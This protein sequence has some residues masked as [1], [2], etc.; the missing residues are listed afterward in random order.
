MSLSI[1]S[2]LLITIVFCLTI[3][4]Q[5]KK[6]GPIITDFGQVWE[7]TNPEFKVDPSKEY[8]AVFDIMNSPTDT[9]KI[10]SSIET[11]ARFLNMHA[12]SGVPLS[13]LKFVL[14]VHNKASKDIISNEAY[15]KRFGVQNPNYDLINALMNAGGQVIFCGQSSISRG[16]PK[17]ELIDGVQMSLSAMTALIHFQ[18]KDYRLIKF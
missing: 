7:I 8:K 11:A 4:A 14:V 1:K 10:N 13:N 16:F 6:A 12:Q 3:S 18:D 9:S 15:N 2:T 17:E 5:E